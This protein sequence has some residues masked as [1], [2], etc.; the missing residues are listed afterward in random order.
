[1]VLPSLF[2][3]WAAREVSAAQACRGVSESILWTQ[4]RGRH[5]S[6]GVER[7]HVS[8]ALHPCKEN[9]LYFLKM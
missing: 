1:M 9:S 7:L 5:P 3:R 8:Y 4:V 2:L 6:G